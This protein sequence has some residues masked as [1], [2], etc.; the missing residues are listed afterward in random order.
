MH[1]LGCFVEGIFYYTGNLNLEISSLKHS[2][3]RQKLSVVVRRMI[4]AIYFVISS[5]PAHLAA[6]P[7]LLLKILMQIV[8]WYT[9]HQANI[10]KSVV[11][12]RPH[13]MAVKSK[14]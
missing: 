2:S 10:E 4:T 14:V 11:K 9:L 12:N 8:L 6:S 5:M 7:N 1:C 13:Q 3:Y